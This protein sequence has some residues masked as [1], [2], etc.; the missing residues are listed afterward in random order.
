MI[1]ALKVNFYQFFRSKVFYV[2]AILLIIGAIFSA[3]L[4]KFVADDPTGLIE[5]FRNELQAQDEREAKDYDFGYEV[6]KKVAENQ[7]GITIESEVSDSEK[8]ISHAEENDYTSS[9]A[10]AIQYIQALSKMASFQGVIDVLYTGNASYILLCIFVAIFTGNT[11]KSRYHINLYSSSL[12]PLNIVA[13]Q[14]FSYMVCFLMFDI[15]CILICFSLTCFLCN[16]FNPAFD[17]NIIKHLVIL[18]LTGLLYLMFSYMIAYLRRGPVLSIILSCILLVGIPDIFISIASLFFDPLKYISPNYGTNY[19]ASGSDISAVSFVV[20]TAAL[21]VYIAIF[22][23][24]TF[25]VAS[26]RDAY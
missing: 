21:L 19:I 10:L 15:I 8:N 18:G 22:T 14:V 6:G 2:V 13:S 3:F 12:S 7:A 1:K 25:F 20:T 24:I 26:K 4:I 11:Y 9:S 5:V 23:G 17:A 16:Y